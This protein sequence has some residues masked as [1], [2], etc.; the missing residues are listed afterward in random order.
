[1]SQSQ[2]TKSLKATDNQTTLPTFMD[3]VR[4]LQGRLF[5]IA[6]V[7]LLMAGLAY[8]FFDSIV[9]FLIAP[10]GDEHELVYLTPGGAFSFIIKVCMYVGAIG[11]LPIFIYHLYRFLLPAVRPVNIR[12]A[13]IYTAISLGLALIGLA[14]AYFIS[15]PAALYFLTS[16]NL[17]NINPMLTID[18]YFSFIMTYML[19]GA[20]L[21]QLPLIITI[22]NTIKPL[23]PGGMMKYQRHL[24]LGSFIV[25]AIISPTPDAL[26]QALLA[27]PVVLMYQASIMIVWLTNRKLSRRSPVDSGLTDGAIGKLAV[28]RSLAMVPAST[29]STLIVSITPDETDSDRSQSTAP[30][31][32]RRA[33]L[34]GFTAA[35]YSR[36]RRPVSRVNTGSPARLNS[37]PRRSLDGFIMPVRQSSNQ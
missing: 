29:T 37:P 3:H 16:F 36:S 2:K 31:R 18:S 27:M 23:T 25:A 4:E 13:I 9:D 34:D 24:I 8:P 14:F 12:R 7:F 28:R 11:A 20:L 32:R 26:N 22:I 10:L 19:A 33:S 5:S 17:H 35:S 21:F 15:L 6:I 30:Q 1:M